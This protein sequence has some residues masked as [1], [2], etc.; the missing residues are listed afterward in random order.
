MPPLTVIA[1]RLLST[2]PALLTWGVWLVL[3]LIG[4]RSDVSLVRLVPWAKA[5]FFILAIAFITVWV[6]EGHSTTWSTILVGNAWG[7]QQIAV[8]LQRRYR[9]SNQELTQLNLNS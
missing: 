3:W 6:V 9:T 5:S 4:R 2:S 7:A 8:W 1:Q